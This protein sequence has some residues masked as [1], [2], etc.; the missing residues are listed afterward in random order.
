MEKS[1]FC[2]PQSIFDVEKMNSKVIDCVQ[3]TAV[4]GK[5]IAIVQAELRPNLSVSAL[6]GNLMDID[7]DEVLH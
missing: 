3:L 5:L 6:F 4:F 1:F 7:S 2:N